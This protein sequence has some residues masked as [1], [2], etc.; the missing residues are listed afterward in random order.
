MFQNPEKDIKKSRGFH[1]WSKETHRRADTLEHHC[2]RP[3][4]NSTFSKEPLLL[5][6]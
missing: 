2:T 5:W 6:L 1:L 4:M 3:E